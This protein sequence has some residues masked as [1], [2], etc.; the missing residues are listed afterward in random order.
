[1]IDDPPG[2]FIFF[3]TL[4][5]TVDLQLESI[6]DDLLSPLITDGFS[7]GIRRTQ[8]RHRFEAVIHTAAGR[9]PAIN[10]VGIL[11]RKVIPGAHRAVT[12]KT[13]TIRIDIIREPIFAAI[14]NPGTIISAA[15][16][17]F[18]S[19]A[20]SINMNHNGFRATHRITAAFAIDE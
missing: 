17:P 15:T 12:I 2:P 8:A 10:I 6:E 20:T 14:A 13:L 4:I 9:M 7:F 1:M 19:S 11:E 3:V 5:L 18:L 16:A